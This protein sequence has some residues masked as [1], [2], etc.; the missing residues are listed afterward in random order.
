MGFSSGENTKSY[1]ARGRGETWSLNQQSEEQ[2]EK[3]ANDPLCIER[4]LC[5][6]Y[7]VESIALREAAAIE[8]SEELSARRD[9]LAQNPFDPRTEVSA[10]ARHIAGRV[11]TALWIIFVL[12][13]SVLE[14]IFLLLK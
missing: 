5:A 8:R 9:S 13:P 4:E 11:V 3:W 6:A 2:I 1:H 7:L 12:L 14:I 10:D